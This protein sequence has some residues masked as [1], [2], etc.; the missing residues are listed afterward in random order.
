MVFNLKQWFLIT[1]NCFQLEAMNFNFGLAWQYQLITSN[2]FPK[3][4]KI[5]SLMQHSGGLTLQDGRRVGKMVGQALQD[6]V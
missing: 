2:V 3:D 6:S 5:Y 1:N 4:Y